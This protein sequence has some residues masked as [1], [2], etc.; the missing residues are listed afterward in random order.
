M[1]G[2]TTCSLS[3][4]EKTDIRDKQNAMRSAADCESSMNRL[5]EADDEIDSAG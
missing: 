4:D 3:A 1:I 2:K 5:S